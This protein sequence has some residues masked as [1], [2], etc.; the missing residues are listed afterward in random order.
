MGTYMV[1]TW[2]YALISM[3]PFC[4]WAILILTKEGWMSSR[5]PREKALR[6]ILWAGMAYQI[7]LP[8]W[9]CYG[10]SPH[11]IPFAG[12]AG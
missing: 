1:G 11:G 6:I 9:W 12:F 3:L 5:G 4:L 2:L 10:L 7:L 8:F